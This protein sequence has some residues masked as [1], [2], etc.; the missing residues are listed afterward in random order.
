MTP[1]IHRID[2]PDVFAAS[3]GDHDAAGR[4]WLAALPRLAADLLDRWDLCPAGPTTHGMASL[5]LPVTGADGTPAVLKLQQVREETEGAP[6]S[7]R[8]CS[9]P[10]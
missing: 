2:V 6:L 4:A 3:F 10:A 9:W 8:T 1:P 7:L 5:V